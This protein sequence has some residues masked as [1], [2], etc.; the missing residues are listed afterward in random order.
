MKAIE[1]EKVGTALRRVER[2]I[3][4]VRPDGVLIRLEA[5]PVLSY[6]QKVVSGEL[7]YVL[8]QGP[9][10]PGSDL[11]G[12]VEATGTDVF[13]LEPGTLVHAGPQMHSRGHFVDDDSILIGLTGMTAHSPRLQ[14]RWKDGAFAEV[15]HYPV[16]C[17]TPLDRVSTLGADRLAALPFLAV[18]YGGLLAAGLEPG[19]TVIINGA[20]GNFG[21]HGVLVA[22]AMGAG[23]VVPTGRHRPTL[24]QLRSIEP[25]RVSPVVLSGDLDAD[26]GAILSAAGSAATVL[27]DILGGGGTGPALAGLRAL[28]PGGRAVLMGALAE[29]IQIP[30]VEIMVRGL[31]LKGNFMYPPMAVGR[32]VDMIAARTLS[33]EGLGPEPFS[34]DAVDSAIECASSKKGLNFNVLTP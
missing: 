8:P 12:T 33:L 19:E 32:L 5:A 23:R 18:P 15:A 11:V 25:E 31:T 30:Y 1:L 6:M 14:S 13:D 16:D 21:A 3:P 27:L 20:T 29:P 4:E 28:N 17:I 22:L 9:F 34:L 10:V 2:P 26:V 7:P 24:E